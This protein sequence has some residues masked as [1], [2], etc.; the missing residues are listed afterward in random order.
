MR[1]RRNAGISSRANHGASTHSSMHRLGVAGDVE[2]Q[3]TTAELFRVNTSYR[4]KKTAMHR[5]TI[6]AIA[7]SAAF[8]ATMPT[9]YA[10][11]G[12]FQR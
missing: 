5:N 8:E 3:Q 6:L 12:R 11:G 7:V 1:R 4:V 10:Q 9:A 2:S